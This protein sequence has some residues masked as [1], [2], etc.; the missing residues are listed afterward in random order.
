MERLEHMADRLSQKYLVHEGSLDVAQK[1][2]IEITNTL[3]SAA[4]SATAFQGY[5]SQGLGLSGLWPYVACPL[6]SLWMGSYGLP[7]SAA[8][9]IALISIG[10][11]IECVLLRSG[12]LTMV[13]GE[14]VGFLVTKSEGWSAANRILSTQ[15]LSASSNDTLDLGRPTIYNERVASLG[16]IPQTLREALSS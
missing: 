16:S 15:N 10:K 3:E 5:M 6:A 13:S 4:S 14:I 12:P 1:R 7:P 8:R 9:N 11:S 2:A